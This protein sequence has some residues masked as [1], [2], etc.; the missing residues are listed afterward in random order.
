LAR[1][2][3]DRGDDIARPHIQIWKQLQELTAFDA[4][5]PGDPPPQKW[6]DLKSVLWPQGGS[7][8]AGKEAYA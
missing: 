8:H 6:S 1:G 7:E 2:P 3:Q 4:L 5:L